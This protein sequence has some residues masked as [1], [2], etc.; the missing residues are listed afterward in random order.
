MFAKTK[1]IAQLVVTL[2]CALT[3][4][5][6][7]STANVNELRWILAP[8]TF[9]VEL[10]SGSRFEFEAFAGYINSEH[11]FIIAASCA[12]VNFLLTAFLVLSLGKLWRDRALKISW[13]LIP[14][15]LVIAYLTT[16][17]ANTVRIVTALWL[18]GNSAGGEWL[19]A[20]QLHR[21]SGILIYFGFLLL[22]CD[23]SA[24]MNH[25][26]MSVND[27][28]R[29]AEGEGASSPS[30]KLL[31]QSVFPLLVYYATTLGIPLVNSV[32]RPAAVTT[33]FWQHLLF[34]LLTPL[35]VILPFAVFR[36]YRLRS[37]G[38]RIGGLDSAGVFGAAGKK[39]TAALFCAVLICVPSFDSAA[40]SNRRNATN[41]VLP[42]VGTIKNYP[43]TGLMTGCGNLYAYP[44]H[45][46]NMAP[47][48]YV[49]LS[50]GDGGNAWMNLDGR[51]VR[52]LQTRQVSGENR[53]PQ[54]YYYRLGTL[55]ISVVIEAFKPEGSAVAESD[56]MFKMKIT[57]RRGRARRIVRA[58]GDSDC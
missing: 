31:R 16:L 10:T 28:L 53:K 43:A 5:Q 14:A 29:L 23:I 37:E 26:T 55:R 35:I 24:R 46:I 21:V 20:D 49:F 22:L 40:Q 41:D 11:N 18:R 50:S 3:L 27:R 54:Q 19:D 32:R 30:R 58:V 25:R 15:T 6:F 38:M 12:G 42:R 8:T 13:T 17:V 34:V 48:A 44:V 4:K 51:D 39:L 2:L 1:N 9:L 52:L 7:Y 57:L 33:D 47:E 36:C 45:R 56:P